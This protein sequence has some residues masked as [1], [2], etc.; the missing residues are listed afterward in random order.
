MKNMLRVAVLLSCAGAVFGATKAAL[1]F[2]AD[3]YPE[4]L[5]QAKQKSL[6]IFVECWAPW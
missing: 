6:P 1:P 4:A 5:A 3:D 2:I